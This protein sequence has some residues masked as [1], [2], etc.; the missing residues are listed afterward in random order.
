MANMA[1]YMANN[2]ANLKKTRMKQKIFSFEMTNCTK[3]FELRIFWT[4]K[5]KNI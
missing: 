3:V 4:I 1:N 2:M 5:F